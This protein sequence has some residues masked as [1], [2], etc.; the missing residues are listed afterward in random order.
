MNLYPKN[1]G[2]LDLD[3]ATL[4]LEQ[5]SKLTNTNLKAEAVARLS[6]AAL[7][8]IA[9]SLRVLALESSLAVQT[10][11]YLLDQ[12]DD[13]EGDEV[14]TVATSLPDI[15]DAPM[16][17]RVQLKT[18]DAKG[19]Y[20][21]GTLDGVDGIDQGEPWV[22]VVWEDA[23]GDGSGDKVYAAH[24]EH[25]TGEATDDVT[26]AA[27]RRAAADF[28]ARFN[29]KLDAAL[30]VEDDSPDVPPISDAPE[31]A[32]DD[33]DDDFEAPDA[34]ALLEARQAEKAKPKKKGKK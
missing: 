32:A 23:P 22:G 25:Y 7:L 34:L 18:P 9:G 10:A 17:T 29:T 27:G 30:P 2:E 33:F 14:G 4:E 13:E 28:A 15:V 3:A 26:D 12:P 6:A 24:L 8:D 20:R 1:G 11:G 16:G 21:V 31:P 19:R 5:S